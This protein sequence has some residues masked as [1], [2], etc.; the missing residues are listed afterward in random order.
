MSQILRLSDRLTT[1]SCD[2][3]QPGHC[4]TFQPACLSSLPPPPGLPPRQPLWPPPGQHLWVPGSSISGFQVPASRH[5][6][7][8]LA[9]AGPATGSVLQQSSQSY[10]LCSSPP[11]FCSRPPTVTAVLPVLQAPQQPS[12]VLQ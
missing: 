8:S 9:A 1:S 4:R 12:Q 7:R 6:R 3:S 10:R 2:S 5:K 11:R